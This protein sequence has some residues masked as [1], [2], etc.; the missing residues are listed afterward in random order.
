MLL[1]E[2]FSVSDFSGRGNSEK[3][4]THPNDVWWRAAPAS[5]PHPPGRAKRSD[6]DFWATEE[7]ETSTI[8]SPKTR[9][10]REK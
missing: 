6:F 2:R 4:R 9:P 10:G 3:R 1:L 8:C 5:P 7:E